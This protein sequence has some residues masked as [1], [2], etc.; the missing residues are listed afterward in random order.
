MEKR[1][2]ERWRRRR[3]VIFVTAREFVARL[4]KETLEAAEVSEVW[5]RRRC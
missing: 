3:E 2:S 5:R 4:S 1:R